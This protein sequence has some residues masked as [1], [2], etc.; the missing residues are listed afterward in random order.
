MLID[1]NALGP[2]SKRIRIGE[3]TGAALTVYESSN[4]QQHTNLPTQRLYGHTGSVYALEY[5]PNG[6]SLA[7]GNF[8]KNVLLWNCD[9]SYSN[10]NILSGHKNAILDL[11]W[12]LDSQ[13][14]ISASADK[15]LMVWDCLEGKRI[16]KLKGHDGIVNAVDLCQRSINNVCSASD[17]CT[18]KLWDARQKKPSCT[19]EQD[20]QITAIA[21]AKDGNSIF[22]GGIDNTIHVWDVR[23]LNSASDNMIMKGH[24]DTIT[25]L[26]LSPNGN[27]LLSNSMDGT[28]R[29]WD[30]RPFVDGDSRECKTFSGA[31]HSA[32]KGL[33]KC[34]WSSD[35][36]MVTGGSSDKVGKHLI[37][38]LF[39]SFRQCNADYVIA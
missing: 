37:F 9:M 29:T 22:T 7:S 5:S 1:D 33:L 30:V 24:T 27:Y 31:K 20:Y 12:S 4:Q 10:Y 28:L 32:D 21:Y 16:R 6:E 19:M 15:T 26:S 35:G 14:L 39:H 25:C 23:Q 34:S 3:D 38:S 2:A 13:N 11:K 36:N 17:D 8:D 18:M